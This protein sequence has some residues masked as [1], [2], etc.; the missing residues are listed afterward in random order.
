MPVKTDKTPSLWDTF[1]SKFR[2]IVF[3][4]LFLG[5]TT[6]WIITSTN[7]KNNTNNKIEVLTGKVNDLTKM[8]EKQG[9]ILLKQSELNGRI[10][11]YMQHQ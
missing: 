11:E 8:V 7:K 3:I 6:G 10:I 9:D 1:M 5:T 2:D 4:I